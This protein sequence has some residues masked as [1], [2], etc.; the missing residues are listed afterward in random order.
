ML[1]SKR[2]LNHRF[3]YAIFV[4]KVFTH[5]VVNVGGEL[6]D[7]I[8][9]TNKITKVILHKR[10]FWKCLWFLAIKDNEKDDSEVDDQGVI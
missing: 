3:L 1:K 10:D 8:H 9:K 2:I 5:F 7:I 4:F 6:F